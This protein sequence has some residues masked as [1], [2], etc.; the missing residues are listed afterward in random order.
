MCCLLNITW[1]PALACAVLPKQ[2]GKGV[3]QGALGF[4]KALA[5]TP[6]GP[7]E[8]WR[9]QALSRI[10]A[11]GAFWLSVAT[12]NGPR[13]DE[14]VESLTLTCSTGH[15]CERR[16]ACSPVADVLLKSARA[17]ALTVCKRAVFSLCRRDAAPAIS[18]GGP[19]L[20]VWQW[21]PVARGHKYVM[22]RR[23]QR[24]WCTLR[25]QLCTR[26]V[27]TAYANWQAMSD[28]W[29]SAPWRWQGRMHAC[30]VQLRRLPPSALL[31]VQRGAQPTHFPGCQQQHA[32]Q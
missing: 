19:W 29:W 3:L 26:Y 4:G 24:A 20:C 8:P 25:A 7:V 2:L 32:Q 14:V 27:V 1:L 17:H 15:S 18:Q 16:Q 6:L 31:A 30:S 12:P 10:L 23:Q 5:A 28:Q 9:K 21:C 13:K 22:R 11:S